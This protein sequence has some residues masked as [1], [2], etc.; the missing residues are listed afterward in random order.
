M[1]PSASR[2]AAVTTT[3]IACVACE[4]PG[5]EIVRER[6]TYGLTIARCNRCWMHFTLDPP[7]TR[8]KPEVESGELTWEAYVG[9]ERGDKELELRRRVLDRL[10]GLVEVDDSRRPQLFDIG[11]G[12]GSFVAL[13][14]EAGF[15]ACGND[16]SEEGVR[17]AREVT[18]V[19]LTTQDITE[20]PPASVDILTMWCVIA[21]VPDPHSFLVAAHR[22]L[23]PGGVLFLR[24]PGW[25]SLDRAGL[26]L[27]RRTDNRRSNLADSRLNLS[28]MFLYSAKSIDEQAQRAGFEDVIAD[29]V[30]HYPMATRFYL[31]RIGKAARPLTPFARGLDALM[32]KNL[33]IRN[34]LLVYARKPRTA[35]DQAT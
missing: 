18:G 1:V 7:L 9:G 19:E 29:R 15:D 30:C 23:R 35:A 26:W 22:V 12:A 21:H 4:A 33:F 10:R 5:A 25:C 27:A 3:T 17:H 11:A 16:L 2:M 28:H 34:A 6:T 14:S 24:T 20:L 31:G 32:D 8:V 13:A